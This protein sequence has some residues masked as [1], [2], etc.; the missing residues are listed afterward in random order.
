MHPTAHLALV[1]APSRAALPRVVGALHARGLA[2]AHLHVE[3]TAACVQVEGPTASRALAVLQR[4]VDVVAVESF[5]P[6]LA[7]GVPVQRVRSRRHLAAA[8]AAPAPAS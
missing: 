1:L 2:I 6:C 5:T 7:A 4:L 3:G 8:A